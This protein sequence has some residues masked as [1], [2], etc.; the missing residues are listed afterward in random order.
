MIGWDALADLQGL[1]PLQ[2]AEANAL[3]AWDLGRTLHVQQQ[4]HMQMQLAGAGGMACSQ[5]DVMAS[6]GEASGG[7]AEGPWR[8]Q[9]R[10]SQQLGGYSCG[11][12][13]P[14]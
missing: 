2:M 3:A 10:Q 13:G 4:Q 1:A 7:S 5:A 12:L 9:Q 8:C 11:C 14:L 6:V